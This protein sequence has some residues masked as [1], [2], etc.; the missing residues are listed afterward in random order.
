MNKLSILLLALILLFS[1]SV[2]ASSL[3][4]HNKKF[5][6]PSKV[7]KS[8]WLD[9]SELNR[10]WEAALVRVPKA[11]GT[12][13]SY[14]MGKLFEYSVSALQ[15]LPTII[16]LHGCAGVWAGTY[17]RLNFLAKSGFA[18]IAP[19]SFARAKYPQSCDPANVKGSMYRGT[20]NIR[21]NDAGHAIAKA[22]QLN[23]VDENNIFL[24]G[25][26]QSGVTTAT[27]KS[28]DDKMSVNA[29]VIEGWTCHA[30]WGEYEGINAP[31]NEPVLALVGKND[32]WFQ[33]GWT[34]GDCGTY[35]NKDNGS[36][37]IV[38]SEGVLSAR[39]ELLEDL[40]LQKTVLEFL[41]KHMR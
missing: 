13:S 6:P 9:A 40:N 39:H 1:Q 5:T 38:L 33:N 24:M 2:S 12:Y 11:N 18:V 34:R 25:H 15:P 20:L 41:R 37:S 28:K 21:Q 27:F 22:K 30:G 29:R 36:R 35:I 7:S 19:V 32:P 16:Y 17:T 8:D 3:G 14:I 23:W 31:V 10:T 4:N 26:S